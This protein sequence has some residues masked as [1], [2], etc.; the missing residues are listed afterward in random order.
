MKIENGQI[1]DLVDP[2]DSQ[3]GM[4]LNHATNLAASLPRYYSGGTQQSNVWIITRSAVVSG[5]SVAFDLTDSGTGSAILTTGMFISSINLQTFDPV[6]VYTY[7]TPVLSADKKTLTVPINKQ[8][9]SSANGLINLVG[10]LL[11]F[12]TGVVFNAAPNGLTV[13]LRM[14]GT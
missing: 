5:G 7:G 6:N 4:T 9:F 1:K 13:Y 11:S 12:L 10:V 8:A 14:E 2:S 3:D